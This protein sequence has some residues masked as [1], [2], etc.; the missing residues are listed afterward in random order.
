MVLAARMGLVALVI[1]TALTSAATERVDVWLLISGALGWSFVPALQLGTGLVLIGSAR[2]DRVRA[3]EDY[4]ATGWPW[5]LWIL[6][7]H[8]LLVMAPPVRGRSGWLLVTAVVPLT[9][10]V[11]LL[12]VYARESLGLTVPEARRRVLLH[13][14]MTLVIAVCY[15]QVAIALWPRIL[16]ALR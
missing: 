2:V 8:A 1:G 4:F 12:A 5:L 10:T 15:V 9:L 13:Q 6:A 16:G 11:R 14:A 3:L 7:A